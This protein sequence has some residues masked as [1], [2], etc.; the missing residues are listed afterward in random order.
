MSP[1]TDLDEF[2]QKW[3]AAWPEWPLAQ[4]FVPESQRATAEAWLA[5]QQEWVEAAW[6]GADPTPGS[7][8]LG[9]WQDELR[10]WDKGARRHPL[11][12]VLQR[13]SAPWAVLAD[14]LDTLR[15]TRMQV[16]QGDA[17][18]A[19]LALIPVERCAL[20]CDAALV[21]DPEAIE[22]ATAMPAVVSGQLSRMWIAQHRLWSLLDPDA[23]AAR[24]Q[25]AASLATGI[26]TGAGS[27]AL[28]IHTAL[29]RGRLKAMAAGGPFSPL[30]PPRVLL[31]AWRA[32]RG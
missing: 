23:A 4:V 12:R 2:L 3:R 6:G 17:D 32:A 20:A 14:A 16:L 1:E 15:A 13:T 30:S 25:T 29:V 31:T 19:A 27:R 7:A 22:P 10:G 24:L 5:L 21:A 18:G 9:W 26:E 11:G 8:K 28:R